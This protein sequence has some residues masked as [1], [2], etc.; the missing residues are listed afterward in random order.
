MGKAVLIIHTLSDRAKAI[1]WV[2]RAPGGTRLTFQG[3]K[4]S[5]PQNDR[6]HAMVTDVAD[7]LTWHGRK[8]PM[9]DWKDFFKHLLKAEARWMPGEDGF[10]VPVGHS[11]AEWSKETMGE[12]MVIIEA[13]GARHGVTFHDQ[14]PTPVHALEDHNV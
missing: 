1:G 3:P 4:R 13:F 12:A 9:A 7:Q 11:S 5:L 8:W 10:P 14:S 2:Q 6:F